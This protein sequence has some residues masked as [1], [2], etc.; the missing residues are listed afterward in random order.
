MYG[1]K[2]STL[3]Q[4]PFGVPQGSL[5]GPILFIIFI[6]DI[7]FSSNIVKFL[8]YADDTNIF[9]S[10]RSLMENFTAM[11]DELGK[12][13]A[14]LKANGL[15]LNADKCEYM[16]FHRKHRKLTPFNSKLY[17]DGSEIKRV[18]STK[19][20]GVY[21]DENIDWNVHTS[22]V[23]RNVSKFIPI[24]Y[25]I[26]DR[27]TRSSLRTVYNSIICPN[28]YYCCSVWGGCNSSIMSA[29]FVVQKKIIRLI[30]SE[31][32]RAHTAPLFDSLKILPLPKVHSYTCLIYVFKLLQRGSQWITVYSN[33][34][35][36]NT[37]LSSSTALA[38]PPIYS[39]H[40][41]R[42]I[43]WVGPSLWNFLP[44]DIR[45]VNCYSLFKRK[46]RRYILS[47]SVDE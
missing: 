18:L 47:N 26:R 6:N 19:F 42:S 21:L 16:I 40:S 14:W 34:A 11:N 33:N 24:V 13:S 1:G 36:V 3:Q 5:V 27:L 43:R 22:H 39:A 38:L 2:N 46:V 44:Q 32:Y 17:I 4:V 10:S 7:V 28:L 12:I 23:I 29:L 45:N 37:R 20:L 31:Q 25:R 30:S 35:N 15:T 8:M 41:R 9:I